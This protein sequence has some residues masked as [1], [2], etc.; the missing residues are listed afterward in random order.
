[1]LDAL[2]SMSVLFKEGDGLTYSAPSSEIEDIEHLSRNSIR[3]YSL[4]PKNA[5]SLGLDLNPFWVFVWACLRTI[6]ESEYA[7][8]IM[9][10]VYSPSSSLIQT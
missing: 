10:Y 8:M 2:Q 6:T 4:A 3:V 1:M 5:F 7:K 9:S